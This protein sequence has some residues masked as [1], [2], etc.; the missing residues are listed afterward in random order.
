MSRLRGLITLTLLAAGPT[1]WAQATAT[2]GQIE[3]TVTDESGGA[4]PSVTVSARN[5]GTGFE[6]TA[7]S[8]TS[9]FY[10]LNLLPL[11][12]YE[13]SVHLQGFATVKRPGVTLRVGETLTIPFPLK[14]AT[15]EESV[16]VTAQAPVVEVARS[17]S[18]NTINETSIDSL[19]INGRRFQ[20]FVLL[21]PGAVVEGQRG[22][23]SI[24]GQRGINASYAIDGASYDNPFF[25]GIKG[26][27]RSGLS[28]TISQEAIQEFQV[29]NAGYSAE[30]GR[31][32]GGVVNAV[33]KSG[34]NDF[35]GS[36]FWYFRNE[37]LSADNPSALV[38]AGFAPQSPSDFRQH[39]FGGSLGGPIQQDKAHF[40]LAYDQQARTE[41]ITTRFQ[42][43]P[44]GVPG[45][46]GEEGTFDRTNDVWTAL[47]RIDYRVSDANQFWVRYNFS[48]NQGDNGLPDGQRQPNDTVLYNAIEK[49]K[50]HTVVAQLSTVFSPTTLN[51]IRVQFA[52]EDRPREPNTTDPTITVTGLGRTGR[53]TFLPSLQDDDRYQFLDNFTLIRGQHSVRAGFDLNFIHVQQPFFL[54][55]AGGEYRF[56]SVA[57][58][59]A[60]A[61]TGVQ[62]YRDFRQGF[63]RA[64]VD[65]WQKEI[66]FYLQ[67]SWKPRRN[68]TVNYGL[69]YEAQINPQPD[70]P[71]PALPGSDRIVSDKNNFGPRLGVAWDPWNDNKG[72]VRA[73]AG[74][75]FSR[76]PGLLFVSPFTTNGRAQLQLTFTPTSAGAPLFPNI[77][78][79]PPTGIATPR[80]DANVFA[81]NFDNP[82][83]LQLSAGAERELLPNL[84]LGIDYVYAKG[85]QLERLF[86]V[87]IAP[88]SGTAADGRFLYRNPRPN[89]AFN[90]ILEAQSTA[91]SSYHGVTLS[92]RKRFTAGESWYNRGLQFQAFYTWSRGKDDD[93]NERNFSGLF[94][95]DWQNLAAEYT[96]SNN[97]IRHNF[98][99]N[100]TWN[101]A[102]DVQL[103]A[104]FL[105][106]SGLPYSH[107]ANQDINF[108]GDFLNDRQ[109]VDGRD[110][111]RNT[112]RQPS[113]KRFDL[114]ISKAVRLG[115]GR[116]LDLAVDV[117]NLLNAENLFVTES[118]RN[119]LGATAGT[120]NPNLDRPNAQTGEPRTAQISARFRF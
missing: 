8:D 107:I 9:G 49:D 55:R 104:I 85:D 74:Y 65:F 27:E 33:T 12:T 4:L 116:T 37:G 20:D 22:G 67:D 120:L 44:A 10:R 59:V 51:E 113:F 90:R 81:S 73:N 23:T 117:F 76:T 47:A 96:Y 66:A 101:L 45:F 57:D 11:G 115:Q 111:G 34:T 36:A 93:S 94:Y 114:R 78:S 14:V 24:S 13:I 53:V 61:T 58:Y 42:S 88:P 17:L 28:Y 87:N 43:S 2:T 71:N 25:G 64:A 91:R 95:Q 105:A 3:G 56:N 54:S 106:R 5:V 70:D 30:F 26:G 48:K 40:F 110:T 92:A 75:F 89:V 31:S 77:L 80:T 60:T 82:R 63:G 15:V 84:S 38:S 102:W 98:V 99:A 41:P 32:G 1:L 118:N 79:Q 112:F 46:D 35:H 103:G 7:S 72:V 119:F 100:T 52:R 83:T 108:D 69:R 62:R 86:D 39:Q 50:T 97:D 18:A 109:F 29:T 21:T 6:R 16:T 68:L 19:P